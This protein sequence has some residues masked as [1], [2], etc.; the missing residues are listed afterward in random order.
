MEARLRS[1]Y[2][3][4]NPDDIRSIPGLVVNGVKAGAAKR[5]I[6]AAQCE[7]LVMLSIGGK[8][9][10]YYSKSSQRLYR[11]TPHHIPGSFLAQRA[12][13][14]DGRIELLKGDIS[15]DATDAL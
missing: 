12:I 15:L 7:E 8:E 11:V 2:N 13:L 5:L 10:L 3:V 4:A 6:S 14:A 1:F 9:H